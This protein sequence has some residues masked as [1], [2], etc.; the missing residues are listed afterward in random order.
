MKIIIAGAG[1]L[2]RLLAYTLSNAAHE[3]VI[4]DSDS[5]MLE[6]INDKLDIRVVEGSCISIDTLK[7]AGIKSADALNQ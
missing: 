4:I 6:H 2:G 1:E 7:N 5:D 3:V